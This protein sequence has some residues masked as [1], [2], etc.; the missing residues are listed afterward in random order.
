MTN[1]SFIPLPHR[2]LLSLAGE[3]RVAFLQGLVSC[4]VARACDGKAL[5]GAFLTPQG[6]FLHDFLLFATED[7]LYLETEADRRADFLRRLGLYRLRARVTIAA[8]DTLRVLAVQGSDAGP[9]LGRTLL[10][11]LPHGSLVFA[12]PRLP[13]SGLRVWLPGDLSPADAAASLI[14][15]GLTERPFT[16]WD[17]H[18]IALGLPDGSRDMVPDKALLLEN[19]FDELGGV[20]WQKGCYMGQELTARTKYRGLVK[21]RLM[22]VAIS[23]AIPEPGTLLLQQGMEAGEMRS[24]CGQT[25][26]A[27][28]RLDAFARFQEAGAPL[29]AG[30]TRLSPRK[31]DWAVF[32]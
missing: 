28:I 21:K 19:G 10:A 25:G 2:S 4:D 5:W 26:L 16:D 20:D 14:A 18:R 1:A 22:P 8:E 9:D 23:G 30:A 15:A 7:R 17:S 13:E 12:D 3:D 29:T 24:A 27:L 11:G 6:K 32:G 31:P